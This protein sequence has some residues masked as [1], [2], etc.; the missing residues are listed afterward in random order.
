MTAPAYKESRRAFL[1][2]NPF[3]CPR[4]L[5]F[6]YRE[7]MRAIHQIAPDLPF[8]DILEVGGGQSGL[9]RL[10]YPRAQVV[11]LDLDPGFADAPCN[12]GEGVRFVCGDATALVFPDGSFDA[13]TMFDLLEHVPE[14]ERAISEAFRVLWPG[15]WL[16]VTT[17]NETWRFPYYRALRRFCPGRVRDDGRVGPRP[18]RLLARRDA[19]TR[20][21][22]LPGP[23][24]VHHAADRPLP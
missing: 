14:H 8:A 12:S 7:K 10:L 18:P 13:V 24:D 4:T 23:R 3:V 22:P 2:R 21:R 11:N 5:G 17:P 1:Q 19:G 9:T 16:L 20:G 15:G 6:F